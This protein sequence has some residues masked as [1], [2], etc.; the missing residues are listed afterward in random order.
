MILR[1]GE[2]MFSDMSD[3]LGFTQ[4]DVGRVVVTADFNGDGLPDMATSGMTQER[5]PYVQIWNGADGCGSGITVAF[6]EMGAQDIGTKIEWSVAGEER[7]RWFL[8]STTFSS[9]G[10]TIHLGLGGQDAADWVR[11][12]PHGASPQEH[13]DVLAGSR[14]DQRSYQ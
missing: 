4:T 7:V 11:I 13:F 2:G 14:I 1:N 8:P 10:P 9:S 5:T 12:T 6:P 3:D